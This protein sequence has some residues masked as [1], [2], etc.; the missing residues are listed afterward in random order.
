MDYDRSGA[1]LVFTMTIKSGMTSSSFVVNI[2]DNTMQDGDK[3]FSIT[4]RV[5]SA[6]LPISIKSDT[7]DV[8]VRDDEGAYKLL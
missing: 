8:T 3:I 6:C 4:F 5:T 7:T 1:P 2:I